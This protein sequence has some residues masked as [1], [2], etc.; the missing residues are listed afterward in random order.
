MGLDDLNAL[1]PTVAMRAF[2]QCCGS[3]K[4]AHAMAAARP[5]ATIEAVYAAADKIDASL[6]PPD[7]L[8]AFHAHPRIGER[9]AERTAGRAGKAGGAGRLDASA[10]WS[11]E[12]Q[13][14]ARGASEVVRERLALRNRDYEARF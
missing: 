5:F 1:S 7:W 10:S 14:G 2:L 12:E 4:W 8:E 13:A 6:E 11:N 3:T 9:S